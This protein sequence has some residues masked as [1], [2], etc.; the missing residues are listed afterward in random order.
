MKIN[1]T[2]T[3]NNF[4][5]HSKNDH[6]NDYNGFV[7]DFNRNITPLTNDNTSDYFQRDNVVYKTNNDNSDSVIPH[8]DVAKDFCIK[9][10]MINM[11]YKLLKKPDDEE[12]Y[13]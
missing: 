10:L 9:I 7:S 11:I 13:I 3:I 6:I 12:D 2:T 1:E 5:N 8:I 4:L